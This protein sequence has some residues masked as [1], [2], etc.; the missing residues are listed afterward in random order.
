MPTTL[1]LIC[2]SCR[3]P[4]ALPEAARAEL[5]GTAV[6][7]AGCGRWWVPLPASSGPPVKLDKGRPVRSPLRLDAYRVQGEGAGAASAPSPG[8]ASSPAAPPTTRIPVTQ[9]A[10]RSLRVMVQGPETDLRGVY[11]LG[12][13]S[14]L[15]GRQGC[16]V[17]LPRAAIPDRAIRIRASPRGF[18]FEGIGGFAIPL[19][20]VS[21]P[22]GTIEPGGGARLMLEPYLLGLETS[23]TPGSPIPDLEAA[24]KPSPPPPPPPARPPDLPRLRDRPMFHAAGPGVD[25]RDLLQDFALDEGPGGRPF[26]ERGRPQPAPAEFDGDMTITDMSARGFLATR[27]GDPLKDLDLQLVRTDGPAAGRVFQLTKSPLVIG[28]VEGDLIIQ[29]RRVSGKHAQ[30][31]VNGPEMYALKDL[32]STNGTTINGRPISIATLKNGD[33]IGFGGVSF[34]FVARAQR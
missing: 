30:L 25:V 28:R 33:V 16:H 32:A 18:V 5:E 29:D 27:A 13:S 3:T 17:N 10:S 2:P 19:G 23:A 24:P 15:I 11:E 9:E 1:R 4:Y 31:D 20:A 21:V 22:S 6:C 14:F 26:E 34:R 7:C 12:G 8:V